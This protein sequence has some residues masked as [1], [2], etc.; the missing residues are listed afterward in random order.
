MSL[1]VVWDPAFFIRPD[2]LV[3]DTV[4]QGQQAKAVIRILRRKYTAPV[5]LW[6]SSR[7]PDKVRLSPNPT[8]GDSVE[9]VFD[10]TA[11]AVGTYFVQVYPSRG[12]VFSIPYWFTVIAGP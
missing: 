3:S 9:M 2:P 4:K 7:M 10:A 11:V 5:E 12:N 6:A 8:A 1:A